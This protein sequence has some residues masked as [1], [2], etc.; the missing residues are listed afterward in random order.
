M[1]LFTIQEANALLPSVRTIVKKI[2]KA[3]RQVALYRDEAKKAAESAEKGGG[4][5]SAGVVYA[6]ALVN[7]T[8]QIAELE[9]N[10]RRI[11][12]RANN[13]R[14]QIVSNGRTFFDHSPP[15]EPGGRHQSFKS[16][17]P[18]T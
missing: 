12:E 14:Q 16:F 10:R 15:V 11:I 3:H 2:Q 6:E 1:K 5:V 7:L 18:H 4:G 17:Y 9:I 13:H 8:N